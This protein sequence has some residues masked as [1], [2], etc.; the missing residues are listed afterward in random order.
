MILACLDPKLLWH[1]KQENIV[2][3]WT[4]L[5]GFKVPR[6]PPGA[7]NSNFQLSN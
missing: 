2:P 6:L 5:R 4:I 3:N 7:K 1:G